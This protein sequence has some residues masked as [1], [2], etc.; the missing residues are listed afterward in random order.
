MA[1]AAQSVSYNKAPR[2]NLNDA[3]GID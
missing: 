2:R 3:A 1:L